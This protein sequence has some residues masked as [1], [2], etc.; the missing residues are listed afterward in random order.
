V[1]DL[2]RGLADGTDALAQR[3]YGPGNAPVWAA[4]E[5]VGD[6]IRARAAPGDRLY[7]AENEAGF[8]WQ[9][10]VRPAS[11]LLY[12]SPLALRP[13]L[14]PEIQRAV[15][16]R[17]PPRFVVLPHGVLPDALQCLNGLG[18][19]VAARHPPAVTVLERG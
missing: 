17:R 9:A 10:G 19:R 18:Y 13:E 12:E 4:V 15:C 7:V 2:A 3:A 11:R 1:V 5:P 8:Y 16:G 6:A 14:V